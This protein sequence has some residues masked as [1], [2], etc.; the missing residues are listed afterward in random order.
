MCPFKIFVHLPSFKFQTLKLLSVELK[1]LDYC[2]LL[3]NLRGDN[4]VGIDVSHIG[5]SFPVSFEDIQRPGGIPDVIEMDAVVRRTKDQ[6]VTFSRAE[7]DTADIDSG[8]YLSNRAV[9]VDV[10]QF[11]LKNEML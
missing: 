11:N 2:N 4:L 1:P 5:D 10:P 7:I 8:L 3:E 6:L 9:T